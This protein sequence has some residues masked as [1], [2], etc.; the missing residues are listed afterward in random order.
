M[1][2]TPQSDNRDSMFAALRLYGV[3]VASG[4]EML[5]VAV[6]GFLL[7]RWFG[8]LPRL[9]I[10]GFLLGFPL[11]LYHMYVGLKQAQKKD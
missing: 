3:V 2:G 10:V 7:D 1:K 4:M 8:T 9:T 6:G 5:V 11:G